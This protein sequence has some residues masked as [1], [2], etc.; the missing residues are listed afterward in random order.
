MSL[1]WENDREQIITSFFSV[2]D[3]DSVLGVCLREL[4]NTPS[5]NTVT[6]CYCVFSAL[7]ILSQMYAGKPGM[8]RSTKKMLAFYKKYM[9]VNEVT[10]EVLYQLRNAVMHNFGAFAVNPV[11]NQQYRFIYSDL[12]DKLFNKKSTVVYEMNTRELLNR[13]DRAIQQYQ[14][15]VLASEVLQ[16]RFYAVYRQTG[17]LMK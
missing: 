11:K 4:E 7:D 9:Q 14:N 10:A 2:D 16:C 3:A 8:R 6:R 17:T 15:D 5:K 1:N 13:F 12:G